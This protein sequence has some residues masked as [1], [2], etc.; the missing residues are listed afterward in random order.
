[1]STYPTSRQILSTEP[2]FQKRCAE[3]KIDNRSRQTL[4][5]PT[6]MTSYHSPIPED[7]FPR[8]ALYRQWGILESVRE[9]R[10]PSRHF[11]FS[12]RHLQCVWYDPV[13]RPSGLRTA[14]GETLVVDD[15]G[16][17]NLEAGPDF[18][19]AVL[20]VGPERRRLCGD[21]EIHVSPSGWQHHGHTNDP[22]YRGV[23]AHVT[24]FPGT[25]APELLPPGTLQLSL[26]AAL[27]RDASFSFETIDVIAYPYA[28]R[29]QTPPCSKVL[30]GWPREQKQAVLDAAGEERLRRKAERLSGR[31]DESSVDQVLYEEV[32]AALGGEPDEVKILERVTERWLNR[33]S[34]SNDDEPL[35]QELPGVSLKFMTGL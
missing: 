32:L 4:C 23:R 24:Y 20:R 26:R 25:V 17:W 29:A 8:A 21:V 5:S 28:G 35:F 7:R 1:M 13:L 12:E 33:I 18:L 30:S 15:P 27:S 14:E 16:T 11:P 19:G 34:F 9:P 10:P 22:R 3:S 2:D 31:I 6:E